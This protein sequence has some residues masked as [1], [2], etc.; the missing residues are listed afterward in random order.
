MQLGKVRFGVRRILVRG[1]LRL[2]RWF[3]VVARDDRCAVLLGFSGARDVLVELEGVDPRELATRDERAAYEIRT[4]VFVLSGSFP[5]GQEP[6]PHFE[7]EP[8]VLE[9]PVMPLGD[10]RRP[11]V[12]LDRIVRSR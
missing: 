5:D 12:P 9:P 11:F 7:V 2:A 1:E 10:L 8:A 6:D 3:R 4:I